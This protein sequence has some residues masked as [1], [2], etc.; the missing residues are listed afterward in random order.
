[1]HIAGTCELQLGGQ[2]QATH[3]RAG[4]QFD[5]VCRLVKTLNGR[6]DQLD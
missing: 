3:Q 5:K 2:A 1:L 6:E 4:K